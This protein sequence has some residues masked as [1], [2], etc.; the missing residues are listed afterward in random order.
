MV[1]ISLTIS[2]VL[3]I[4]LGLLIL[5]WPKILRI[6]LGLYFLV[7]GILGLVNVYA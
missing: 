4:I 6:A 2:A 1:A 7:I 3:S 5:V